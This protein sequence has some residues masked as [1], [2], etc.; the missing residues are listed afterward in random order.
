MSATSGRRGRA[1]QGGSGPRRCTPDLEPDGGPRRAQ[2]GQGGEPVRGPVVMITAFATVSTAVQAM[3]LGAFD[4][5][6]KPFDNDRF[7]ALVADALK[8]VDL[9]LKTCVCATKSRPATASPMLR[10]K[11]AEI[12]ACAPS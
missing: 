12:A 7:T 4:Y 6:T 9:K 1:F 10:F 8:I 11:R 5:L 2:A 3:K